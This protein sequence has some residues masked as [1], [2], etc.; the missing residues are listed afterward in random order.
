[1]TL[2]LDTLTLTWN[3]L[4]RHESMVEQNVDSNDKDN[5]LLV[6]NEFSLFE[7]KLP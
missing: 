5:D 1:M 3:E 7:Q 2:N 4:L 6:L